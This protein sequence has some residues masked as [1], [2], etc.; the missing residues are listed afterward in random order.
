MN[1]FA[2][3]IIETVLI[4]GIVLLI[5]EVVILGFSTFFLFFAGLAAVATA[6]SMW[7]GLLPE[8]YLY[9]VFSVA[10]FTALFAILLWK[11]L[12][13]MQEDVDTKHVSN[14]IVGHSFVLPDNIQASSP[15][16]QKPSYQYS[17]IAWRLNAYQDISKGTLVEVTQSDVGV[18]LVQPK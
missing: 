6:V 1:W 5:I 17:G 10:G 7:L 11:I 13:R 9:A 15:L 16:E 2:N 14:D 4:I 12:A 18:L 8:T 3:N